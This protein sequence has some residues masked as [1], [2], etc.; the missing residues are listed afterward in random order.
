MIDKLNINT[1]LLSTTFLSHNKVYFRVKNI[2]DP[3][4][5]ISLKYYLSV[6]SRTFILYLNLIYVINF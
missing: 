2:A 5:F 1:F 4:F 3:L 6:L